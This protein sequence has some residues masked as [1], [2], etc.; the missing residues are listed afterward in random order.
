M[1]TTEQKEQT[2]VSSSGVVQTIMTSLAGMK[3]A[4][5]AGAAIVVGLVRAH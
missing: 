4:M 5:P 2:R 3:L 1:G